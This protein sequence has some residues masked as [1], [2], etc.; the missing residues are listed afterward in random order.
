MRRRHA[1]RRRRS[2]SRGSEL[3]RSHSTR[4][5]GEQSLDNPGRLALHLALAMHLRSATDT[6]THD[7]ARVNAR[8]S[9]TAMLAS[10]AAPA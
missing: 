3:G 8:E 10:P 1:Q 4:C 7:A 2:Q 9:M 5:Q 6:T